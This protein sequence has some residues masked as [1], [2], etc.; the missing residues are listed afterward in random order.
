MAPARNVSAAAT[1][2]VIPWFFKKYANFAKVVVL[3]VPFI[4]RNSTT[5]GSPL[6]FFSRMRSSTSMLPASS[7]SAET[8]AVSAPCTNVWI[9]FLF[10]LIPV[11]LFFRSVHMLSTTSKATSDCRSDISMLDRMSSM[12]V[13]FSSFSASVFEKPENVLRRLSNISVVRSRLR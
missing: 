10:T 13:S 2:T 1:A 6:E 7:K 5:K 9:S 8:D 3:P 4:P 11:S 12:S